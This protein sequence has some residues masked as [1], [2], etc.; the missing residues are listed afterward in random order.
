MKCQNTPE[1]PKSLEKEEWIRFYHTYHARIRHVCRQH[2]TLTCL[3]FD[4]G[5]P[6]AGL[7]LEQEFGI[8]ASHWRNCNPKDWTCTK[9]S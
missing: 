3:E 1:L 8:P 6:K 7:M 9:T 2:A 5:N 4:I